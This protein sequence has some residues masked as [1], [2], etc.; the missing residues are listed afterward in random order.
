LQEYAAQRRGKAL[1]RSVNGA[2]PSQQAFV[3]RPWVDHY[4]CEVGMG[5]PGAEWNAVPTNGLTPSAA[6]VYKCAAM[7]DRNLACTASGP[8]YAYVN[9]R[10]AVNLCRYWIAESYA[11][12]QCFMTPSVHQW[13]YTKEKG[14]HWYH[15]KPEDFADLYQFVRKNAVLFD[16]YEAVAQV[17]VIFNNAA[18]RKWKKEP[19]AAAEALLAANVPFALVAAGDDLLDLRLDPAKLAGF[20]CILASG[21]PMPDA[22]QQQVW[23]QSPVQKRVIGKNAAEILDGITPWLAVEN[24]QG[25][26]ALPRRIPGHASAPLVVHLL[27]RNYDFATDKVVPQ[28]NVV[29]RLRSGLLG[30]QAPK[31]CAM[32]TPESGPANLTVA[33]DADGLVVKIPELKLW[34]ILRLE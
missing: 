26:W 12:G 2:P 32:F 19:Q 4:S 13:C 30:G 24:A 31:T 25:I 23:E 15:A 27:N 29:L 16:D 33:R 6:F 10:N 18:W 9:D 22:S 11:F 34:T 3:V 8:S 5:A 14:T 7:A 20:E 21:D 1:V 17:G 28:P